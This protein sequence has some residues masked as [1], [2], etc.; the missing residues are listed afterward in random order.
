MY[1]YISDLLFQAN[2]FS[3]Q[4][5]SLLIIT[6]TWLC[7][8]HIA[9]IVRFSTITDEQKATASASGV[10]LYAWKDVVALV[11]THG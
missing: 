7:N 3:Y 11:G 1:S 2:D 6:L 9:A 10:E 5:D 4:N 8:S